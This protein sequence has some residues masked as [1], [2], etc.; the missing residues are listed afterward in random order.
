MDQI[1]EIQFFRP[2]W[3]SKSGGTTFHL[4]SLAQSIRDALRQ[5]LVRSRYA[6][7][8]G[9]ISCRSLSVF[10]FSIFVSRLRTCIMRAYTTRLLVV[11]SAD[12]TITGSRTNNAG[13]PESKPQPT[14]TLPAAWCV[15]KTSLV[16]HGSWT[17]F[18]FDSA[19]DPCSSLPHDT[20]DLL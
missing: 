19:A 4:F 8:F 14:P 20:P 9:S 13:H 12:V 6:T 3:P 17:K 1:N 15:T 18:V 7:L 11:P 2:L 16:F 10:R 5:H